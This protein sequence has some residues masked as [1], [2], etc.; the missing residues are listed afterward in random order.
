MNLP[1]FRVH[2]G[3]KN[4]LGLDGE[5]GNLQADPQ[6]R[7]EDGEPDLVGHLVDPPV[8]HEEDHED[9]V[10]YLC[11]HQ[12]RQLGGVRA[13]EAVE[14]PEDEHPEG[15]G[16]GVGEQPLDPGPPVVEDVLGQPLGE[17][18]AEEAA[19]HR[20]PDHEEVNYVVE[21]GQGP[22]PGVEAEAPLHLREEQEAEVLQVPV[23]QHRREEDQGAEGPQEQGDLVLPRLPEAPAEEGEADQHEEQVEGEELPAGRQEGVAP[24]LH[25]PEFGEGVVGLGV[26]GLEDAVPACSHLPKKLV[27]GLLS[28]HVPLL[29]LKILKSGKKF[30][31]PGPITPLVE[32]VKL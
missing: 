13:E 25:A 8:P 31:H 1:K 22:V 9:D 32:H 21:G 2:L 19:H 12:Q 5:K 15:V 4:S 17:V 27:S 11:P 7:E 20:E 10:Y 6:G 28:N 26:E 16:K 23:E 3:R 18:V 30:V 24:A 29:I 14:A